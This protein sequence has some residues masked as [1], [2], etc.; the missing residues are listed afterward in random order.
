M[1]RTMA[2]LQLIFCSLLL[3]E[4][5]FQYVSSTTPLPLVA[6]LSDNLIEKTNKVK[7][8]ICESKNVE[9]GTLLCTC[10]GLGEKQNTLEAQCFLESNDISSNN[11][12][13]SL[14]APSQKPIKSFKL[15]R[16]A[17]GVLEYVPTSTLQSMTK[18]QHLLFQD[19]SFTNISE[20]AFYNMSN[21]KEINLENNNIKNLPLKTFDSLNRLEV[22]YMTK[23]NFSEIKQNV[24][25]NLSTLSKLVLAQ[26]G[27]KKIEDNSF[28]TLQ[29][30]TDLDLSKNKITEITSG[31][32]NGLGNLKNLDLSYNELT[33]I[34]IDYLK[35]AR[36]LVT[37]NLANNEI[38]T[39]D[40][41]ELIEWNSWT[42]LNLSN[43]HLVMS[44]DQDS[45]AGLLNL[46]TLDLSNNA[47]KD[48]RFPNMKRI[49][50]SN[51]NA[52]TALKLYLQGNNLTCNSDLSW[53]FE[54]R[55]LAKDSN[56]KKSMSNVTCF[57]V[58]EG[59]NIKTAKNDTT[60]STTTI[61][62]T[63]M[64]DGGLLIDGP[65]NGTMKQLWELKLADLPIVNT[66]RTDVNEWKQ[67]ETQST[68]TSSSAKVQILLA[69]QLIT[70]SIIFI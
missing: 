15:M 48:L 1:T 14:F 58:Y 12:V 21:I 52:T 23:N 45:F 69:I 11:S 35:N 24:F 2:I 39:F 70:L 57:L 30:L 62:E 29:A 25:F 31:M 10:T 54:L 34:K 40:Y 5:A 7:P 63:N 6:E 28:E 44:S 38:K 32:F 42:N 8:D 9:A 61:N 55:D 50:A 33:I 53:M 37:L 4:N 51:I 68:T 47:M 46:E 49:Y 17:Y 36:D 60:N 43:N 16:R 59:K 19:I 22:I 18:L 13:W 66:M 67:K 20:R 65:K 64:I 26:N 27:I 3:V 41:T 56:L